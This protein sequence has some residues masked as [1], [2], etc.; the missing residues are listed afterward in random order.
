MRR[1]RK[2]F[3]RPSCAF[4]DASSDA[5]VFELDRRAGRRFVFVRKTVMARRLSWFANR[6][7]SWRDGC[8]EREVAQ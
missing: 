2:G 5:D 3:I 4:R 7:G 1:T 8:A 6:R